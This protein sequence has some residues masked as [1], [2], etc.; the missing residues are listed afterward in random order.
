MYSQTFER[1]RSVGGPPLILLH[2]L[3]ETS[4]AW[5]PVHEQLSRSF[6]VITLDLPGFGGSPEL[7]AGRSP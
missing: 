4:V 1:D 5:R 3:G 6:D 7:P 2:G